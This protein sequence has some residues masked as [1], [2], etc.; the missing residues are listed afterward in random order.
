M[1]DASRRQ[2]IAF[3]A[4]RFDHA[5][6]GCGDDNPIGL[7]LHF[8]PSSDGVR[9]DFTPE[10]VH[11]G[12]DGIIHGGIISTLLDEAMAWATTSAGVWSF[13]AE[14]SVRF[15]EPLSVGEP[16]TVTA[17]VTENRGRIIATAGE[18][19]RDRDGAIIATATGTFVRVSDAVAREWESRYLENG[20]ID[21][22]E[23]GEPARVN[24]R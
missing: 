15:K 20:W 17:R 8:S 14:M 11:Q 18:L 22:N 1:I 9:A 3:Q 21:K 5:C 7:H 19:T 6:F 24:E 10:T 23:S 16:T 12:F 13:T 2:A 4:A